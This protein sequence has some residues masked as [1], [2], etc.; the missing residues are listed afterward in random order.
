MADMD[1]PSVPGGSST[2]KK[3]KSG[4]TG[5]EK[6]DTVSDAEEE[7]EDEDNEYTQALAR[8]IEDDDDDDE[9]GEDYVEGMDEGHGMGDGLVD[10]YQRAL[11][12]DAE[13]SGRG[14]DASFVR[15]LK[16]AGGGA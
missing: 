14:E 11:K 1:L 7:D 4:P 8:E 3:S 13:E 5:I 16:K 2:V 6:A 10:R 12:E 15:Y 9:E